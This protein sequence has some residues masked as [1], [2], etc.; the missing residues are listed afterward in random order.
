[1]ARPS[2]LTSEERGRVRA[3]LTM[4]Y[5][6]SEVSRRLGLSRDKVRVVAKNADLRCEVMP[7]PETRT[8]AVRLAADEHELLRRQ[9]EA[10]GVTLSALAR[11]RLLGTPARNTQTVRY[12]REG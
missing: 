9:A 5:N 12:R 2:T 6:A 11:S 4:G 10:E 1:M 8:V 3:A 7:S